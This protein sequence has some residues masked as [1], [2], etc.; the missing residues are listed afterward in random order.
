MKNIRSGKAHAFTLAITMDFG[1]PMTKTPGLVARS[2]IRLVDENHLGD[3]PLDRRV[4]RAANEAAKDLFLGN[5]NPSTPL[6]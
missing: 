6:P 2:G 5:D 4:C 3:D 1:R